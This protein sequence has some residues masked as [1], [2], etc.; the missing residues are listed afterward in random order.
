MTWTQSNLTSIIFLHLLDYV[1]L[2]KK[3]LAWFMSNFLEQ[4]CVH[5]L[6]KVRFIYNCNQAQSS[7]SYY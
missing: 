3:L 4:F 2:Q 5:F 7:H 1:K 6:L